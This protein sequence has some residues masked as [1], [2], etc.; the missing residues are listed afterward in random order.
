ME[1]GILGCAGRMGQMLVREVISTTNCNLSGGTESSEH[2]ALGKDIAAN[3]GLPNCGISI[4]EDSTELFK[5]SDVIVDFT[6]AKI[7][8]NHT[9]LAVQHGTKLI[10]GT[11]GHDEEQLKSIETASGKVTIVKAMNFSV[12]I[13]IL[14]KLTQ[15][16]ASLLDVNYDIEIFEMHHKHKID[17]PSGTAI[18]LGEAAAVGRKTTLSKIARRNRDGIIGE[19]VPGEIGFAALRGGNVIGEHRVMFVSDS[20]RIELGHI[21]YS[22]ELF[23]KGAIR[24]ALWSKNKNPGLYDM[25]DVLGMGE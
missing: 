4:R 1:I 19:R 8:K 17:A 9:D 11:T 12:G 16:I 25:L 23:A 21:A 3:C 15:D 5:A 18:G 20:E 2:P 24:A 14:T 22:R 10:L 7:T 13:N 6:L